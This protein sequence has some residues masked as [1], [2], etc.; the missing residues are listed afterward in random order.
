MTNIKRNFLINLYK[1]FDLSIMVIA[2]TLSTRI[3][4]FRTES[5]SFAE[6]INMRVEIHN[7]IIFLGFILIWFIIFSTF[8]FYRS[9]RLSNRIIEIID[10]LKATVL[11]TLILWILS[12]YFKI[13]IVTFTF[14]LVFFGTVSLLTILCRLTFRIILGI[15]RKYG[16]NLRH[17]LIVGTNERAIK[18]KQYIETRPELGYHVIGFVDE[19]WSGLSKFHKTE[20]PLVTDFKNFLPYIRKHIVDEIVINIPMKSYYDQIT[21]ITS[22][23]QEQG[24]IVHVDLKSSYN[25]KL[26]QNNSPLE[27]IDSNYWM[28]IST[29]AL[30]NWLLEKRMIDFFIAT[31]L[32]VINIPLFLIISIMIKFNSK[33]PIFFKQ[34]RIGLNK[35]IFKMFKFRTMVADA[36]KKQSELEDLNEVSGPVFKIK[37]D[38]RI[39]T[40]GKI[41]RN[42]SIDELPQLINILK[43]DMSLIGPRPLPIRDYKGFNKDWY[44]RRF[45]V[46]PGITGLWQ[47]SG[48]NDISFDKWMEL[49]NEYIDNWSLWLDLKIIGKTIPVILKR[50][51]M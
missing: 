11:G 30:R 24:I 7:F 44:R 20:Y 49:D 15:I 50:T 14:I 41:L 1:M 19:E 43:G 35:R 32:L 46:R 8:N 23:C 38:P 36:E 33:G 42:T 2:F 45:S 25:L 40:L 28:T 27:I 39:T 29:S 51:G 26:E 12:F 31:V 18:F 13:E 16:R 17:L 10:I 4:F 47:V 22:I 37:N 6:F 5:I 21:D 3:T 9:K 48:R 34:D